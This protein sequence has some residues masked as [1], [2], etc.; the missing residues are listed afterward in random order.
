MK[1]ELWKWAFDL[2]LLRMVGLFPWQKEEMGFEMRVRHY[3]DH[4][5]PG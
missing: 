2:A 3:P 1:Q 5:A 4:T